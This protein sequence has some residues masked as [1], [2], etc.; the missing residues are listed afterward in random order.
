MKG[1]G[2]RAQRARAQRA[3][4]TRNEHTRAQKN[5]TKIDKTVYKLWLCRVEANPFVD[6][7]VSR[8]SSA[9]R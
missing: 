8:I 1:C 4:Q 5:Y 7:R 6:S 2:G 9:S 3:G